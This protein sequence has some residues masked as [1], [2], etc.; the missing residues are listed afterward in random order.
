MKAVILAGGLGT[1]LTEKTARLP[2][3]MVE[4][5]GNPIIWHIMSIYEKSGITDFIICAGYKQ[6][7]IKQYFTTITA[8]TQIFRLIFRPVQL[9]V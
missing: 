3:P 9:T 8:S 6:N 4:V 2:K 5:G 1:R 7:V